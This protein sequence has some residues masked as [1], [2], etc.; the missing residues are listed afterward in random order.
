MIK[1]TLRFLFY[2]ILSSLIILI[3]LI[4]IPR[5][6]SIPSPEK[7]NNTEYWTLEDSTRIGYTHLHSIG[8]QQPYPIIYVHGGP[9]GPISNHHIESLQP[10][11]KDGFDVYLYDQIGNGYSDRLDDISKYTATKHAEDLN[12]IIHQIDAPK[13]ILIGHSWGALLINLFLTQNSQK[14]DR[15]ILSCPGPILPIHFELATVPTPD[16]L[17]IYAPFFSNEQG[18]KKANNIRTLAMKKCAQIFS[19][20]LTSDKEADEFATYLNGELNKSTV[21]DT[22]I[23]ITPTY[24]AGFYSQVMT[25]KSFL[26]IPDKRNVLANIKNPILILKGQY[27]NQKWGYTNEYLDIYSNSQLIV[28]PNSGHSISREQPNAYMDHIRAFLLTSTP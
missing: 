21:S 8:Q 23:K 14:V 15:V 16:S 10:L 2:G 12:Q 5:H 27:D 13:V 26:Q 22:A 17:N 24:G 19:W 28:I 20:K 6:Y 4:F 18:N 3:F 9:G 25:V 11:T 1:K 7:R